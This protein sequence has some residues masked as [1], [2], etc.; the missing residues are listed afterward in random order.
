[1]GFLYVLFRTLKDATASLRYAKKTKKRQKEMEKAKRAIGR[2]KKSKKENRSKFCNMEAINSI[3]DP[4]KFADRLFG[5]LE[6]R[7]NEKLTFRFIFGMNFL[8]HEKVE[9]NKHF[10]MHLDYFKSHF[11]LA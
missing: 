1:M 9:E 8:L 10:L 5:C 4:Q 6:T 11:V 7:K 2:E 3:Y